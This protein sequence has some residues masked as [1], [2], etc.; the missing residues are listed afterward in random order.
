MLHTAL[1]SDFRWISRRQSGL[2]CQGSVFMVFGASI[3]Q[4]GERYKHDEVLNALNSLLQTWCAQKDAHSHDPSMSCHDMLEINKIWP[5]NHLPDY[6]KRDVLDLC[7]N[8]DGGKAMPSAI[9]IAN[10]R[11]D[12]ESQKWG[13]L[14]SQSQTQADLGRCLDS[15][16][17]VAAKN[18]WGSFKL[19]EF[20]LLAAFQLVAAWHVFV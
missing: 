9:Y 3:V 6:D 1:Y 8:S 12:A 14:V 2:F 4:M 10:P 15:I 13:G 16:P 5:G 17:Q 11:R 18:F 20:H 19:Q 7:K